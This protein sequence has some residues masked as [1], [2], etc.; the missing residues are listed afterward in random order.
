MLVHDLNHPHRLPGEGMGDR[1]TKHV[2]GAKARFL[3]PRRVESGVRSTVCDDLALI[4][5]RHRACDSLV[6]GNL[7][8][9]RALRDFRPEEAF[10]LTAAHGT[11]TGRKHAEAAALGLRRVEDE[12]RAA[13]GLGKPPGDLDSI[14]QEAIDCLAL[15]F[16]LA[17]DGGD[18]AGGGREG[19]GREGCC[20]AEGHAIV[21]K[22]PADLIS[23]R[24]TPETG[25]RERQGKERDGGEMRAPR[26]VQRTLSRSVETGGG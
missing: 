19:E 17:A 3:V 25:Q 7:D 14:R 5:G 16:T 13:L 20:L 18:G 26:E 15:G 12:E 9:I 4:R 22:G 8:R 6:Q 24:G 11:H 2:P 23:T 1:N 21:V 10:L